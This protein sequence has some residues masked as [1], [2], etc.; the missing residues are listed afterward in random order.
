M[1]SMSDTKQTP[2]QYDTSANLP[3]EPEGYRSFP[4]ALINEYESQPI[5]RQGEVVQ[6][7]MRTLAYTL[8][9]RAKKF[10]LRVSKAE[11]TKLLALM[12][13]L[14]GAYDRAFR[15]SEIGARGP[16]HILIQ[17]FGSSGAGQAIAHNLTAMIPDV[18]VVDAEVVPPQGNNDV[19]STQ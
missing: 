14:G 8:S 7:S 13:S 5:V 11:M 4:V 2:S 6:Q 9:E 18:H 12:Q 15:G 19:T 3:A 17:L 16:Q 10:S 1:Y